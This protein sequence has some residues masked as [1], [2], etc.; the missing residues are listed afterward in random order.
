MADYFNPTV[1]EPDIPDADMTPL[2]RLL[3]SR[4]F[5]TEQ[6][7]GMTYLFSELGPSN[8][9]YLSRSELAAALAASEN[10]TSNT[11]TFVKD[12]L[13]ANEEDADEIELDITVSGWHFLL[14]DVVRRSR[15]IPYMIV[16][17]AFTCSKMRPDGFGGV[18][19]LITADEVMAK[20]TYDLLEEFEAK[21]RGSQ[22]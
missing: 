18:A 17:S 22:V 2:E 3:L 7:D 15:T 4:I 12:Q 14:Q 6:C 8:T 21:V 16:K 10:V 9:I 19:M 1:V 11:N 20:S 5:E 13:A